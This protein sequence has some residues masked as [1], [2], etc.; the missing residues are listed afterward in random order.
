[1]LVEVPTISERVGLSQAEG[2]GGGE[3]QREEPRKRCG[4][5]R[6]PGTCKECQGLRVAR[7]RAGE[8]GTSMKAQEAGRL[9]AVGGHS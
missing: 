4:G 6:E 8:E 1:M 3:G 2:A 7:I 9:E 5:V